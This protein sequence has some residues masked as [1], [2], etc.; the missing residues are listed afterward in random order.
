MSGTRSPADN[1]YNSLAIQYRYGTTAKDGRGGNRNAD[2]ARVRLADEPRSGFD[3][4]VWTKMDGGT[5]A[6]GLS[7]VIRAT[8][9]IDKDRDIRPED[10]VVSSVH[11]GIRFKVER[12]RGATGSPRRGRIKPFQI[13]DLISVANIALPVEELE[14]E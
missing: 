8:L 4:G 9:Y 11:P 2:L 10:V 1:T 6:G 12:V 3:C 5:Q 13:A 14:A 7:R